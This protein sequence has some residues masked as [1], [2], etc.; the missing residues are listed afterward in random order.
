MNASYL[1]Q[2]LQLQ[3][4]PEGGFYKETYRSEELITTA[5]GRVRN[6]FTSIYFLLE[7]EEKSHFH[8]IK[9]DE[10]WYFHQGE[11]MEIVVLQDGELQILSLGNNLEM[12]EVPFLTILANTWF[13]SKIKSNRGYSLVS[14]VVG[15]GFDFG[16]FELANKKQLLEEYPEF[17]TIIEEFTW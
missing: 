2:K 9:S 12:G 13:A 6:V 14:C 17:K 7:N 4:H 15:P 10:T 3:A 11:T 16:D 5:D 1:I 8:R